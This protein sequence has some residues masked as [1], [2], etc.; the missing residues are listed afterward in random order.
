MRHGAVALCRVGEK[1]AG[2]L[3]TNC[4]CALLWTL[5]NIGIDIQ[6]GEYTH[7]AGDDRLLGNHWAWQRRWFPVPV[8]LMPLVSSRWMSYFSL[9]CFKLVEGRQSLQGLIKLVS[10]PARPGQLLPDKPQL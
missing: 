2:N 1:D 8:V 3:P 4:I 7:L 10:P 5:Q 6:I 9:N